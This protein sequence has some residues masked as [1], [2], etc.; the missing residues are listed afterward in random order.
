L[1]NPIYGGN[2]DKVAWK[3]IGFPGAIAIYSEHIKTLSQD[4]KYDVEPTSILVSRE[5]SSQHV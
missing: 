3:M 2:R 4:K 5:A 1:R